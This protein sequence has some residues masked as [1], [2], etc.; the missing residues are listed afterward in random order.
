MKTNQK[1]PQTRKAANGPRTLGGRSKFHNGKTEADDLS[2]FRNE[3]D[4]ELTTLGL[5]DEE[6]PKGKKGRSVMEDD[7]YDSSDSEYFRRNYY[8]D[9]DDNDRIY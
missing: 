7:E 6:S 3:E 1:A 2:E 5:D 8:S 9:D 4:E